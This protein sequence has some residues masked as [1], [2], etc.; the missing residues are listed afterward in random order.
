MLFP[1]FFSLSMGFFFDI[2]PLNSLSPRDRDMISVLA[3]G[4]A[5]SK[6]VDV[7]TPLLFIL[8]LYSIYKHGFG[9]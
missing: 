6:G 2:L 9:L 5:S 8:I 3:R 4:S 7:L 1:L